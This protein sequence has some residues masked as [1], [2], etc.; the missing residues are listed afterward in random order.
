MAVTLDFTRFLKSCLADSNRRPPP[1]QGDALPA[2]PRQQYKVSKS[3]QALALALFL[4]LLM[5]YLL[6]LV[7][8]QA[9]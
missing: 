5:H 7:A 6:P 2:E 3:H 1:Y 4:F 8:Y 9:P